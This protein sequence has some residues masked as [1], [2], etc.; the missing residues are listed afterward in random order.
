[1]AVKQIKCESIVVPSLLLLFRCNVG[2]EYGGT[3]GWRVEEEK[4]EEEDGEE[5]EEEKEEDE[6]EEDEI[7]EAEEKEEE[8]QYIKYDNN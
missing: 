5:Q 2:E 8:N 7:E 1:M 3:G 4:K 6:R